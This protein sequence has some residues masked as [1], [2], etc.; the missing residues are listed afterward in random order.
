MLNGGYEEILGS[1]YDLDS[2]DLGYLDISTCLANFDSDSNYEL[3]ISLTITEFAG[4]RGYPCICALLDIQNG[5]VQIVTNAYYGGGTMGGDY[6]DIKYY[7]VT[8]KHVIVLDGYIRD[9]IYATKAYLN[10]YSTDGLYNI[11]PLA[12]IRY[13][14]KI[15]A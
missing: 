8:G 7:M 5:N 4:P 3:L 11:R 2:I 14:G 15:G 12:K 10:I 6:L 9:G 13:Y 1:A